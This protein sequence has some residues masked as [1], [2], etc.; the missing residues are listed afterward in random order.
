MAY[1]EFYTLEDCEN[2]MVEGNDIVLENGAISEIKKS[3]QD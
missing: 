3:P 2:L 1:W